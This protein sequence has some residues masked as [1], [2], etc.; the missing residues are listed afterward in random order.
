MGLP[1]AASHRGFDTRSA[2]EFEAIFAEAIAA[3]GESKVPHL[4]IGGL[5]SAA[6]GRPRCSADI[7]I[8]V[9]PADADAALRSFGR[10]GFETEETNPHWLYKATKTGVLVDLLFKGPSDIY[11]D[12]A[13]LERARTLSV[14]GLPV[15]VAPAEDLVVMKALVHD[16]E[17]PRHWHDALGLLAGNDVD[18]D[19]LVWRARKGNK[20]V[21]SLLLYALSNDLAVPDAVIDALLRQSRGAK[22]AP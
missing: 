9:R 1:G 21:L 18:W 10:R 22:E 11:L 5:A 12:D 19:Y 6:L 15:P 7:D 20:R 3:L 2:S 4:L 13:M 8:L 16:E 14:M 17:T